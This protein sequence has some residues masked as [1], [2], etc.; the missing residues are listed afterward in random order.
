MSGIFVVSSNA[1]IHGSIEDD[2]M[3]LV[4]NSWRRCELLLERLNRIRIGLVVGN[5]LVDGFVKNDDTVGD[6]DDVSVWILLVE[7]LLWFDL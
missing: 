7:I 5:S 2:D 4:R 3:T 1:C 6:K